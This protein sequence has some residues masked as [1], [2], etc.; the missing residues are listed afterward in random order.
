MLNNSSNLPPWMCEVDD[1]EDLVKSPER[2]IFTDTSP[3]FGSN[4]VKPGDSGY[5][6]LEMITCT[7]QPVGINMCTK[8]N[9][10]VNAQIF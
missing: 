5:Y 3:M 8:W 4:Q 2:R 10:F 6:D 7:V 9:V 1:G